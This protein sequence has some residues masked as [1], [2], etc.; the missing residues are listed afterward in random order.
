MIGLFLLAFSL[1]IDALGA[2]FT[3]GLKRIRIPLLSRLLFCLVSVCCSFLA[4]TIGNLLCV[5]LP[6]W[7][8]NLISILILCFLGMRMLAASFKEWQHPK[9]IPD[10]P[11]AQGH[12]V[13]NALGFTITIVRHPLKGDWDKSSVIDPLEAVFLGFALSLDAFG[14]GIGYGLYGKAL[15]LALPVGLFQFLFLTL[16]QL[17]G[18]RLNQKTERFDALLSF[19]PGILLLLLALMRLF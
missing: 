14:A 9:A 16:G 7:V 10:P 13:W 2:G 15:A 3:Y 6:F 1:S 5:I 19:L 18:I 11:A 12:W 8:G 4:A 17:S